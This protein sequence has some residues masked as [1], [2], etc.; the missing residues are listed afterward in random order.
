MRLAQSRALLLPVATRHMDAKTR[1]LVAHIADFEVIRT[2]TAD[3]GADP[4]KRADQELPAEVQR[5]AEGQQDVSLPQDHQRG[6][7]ADHLHPADRQRRRPLLRALHLGRS[8]YK[9]LNLLNR[10]F[11][12]RK[13]DKKI[14]GHDEVCL[15]YHMHQCTAPCISAVDRRDLHAGDRW[16][17]ALPQRPGRRNPASRSKRRWSRPSDAWNFERAAEL[18]DRINA[19]NHVLE[20]QKIVSPNGHERRRH[21]GRPGCGRRCRRAGG[22]PAQRQ[23]ARLRVLPDAGARRRR[24][25]RDP[26][27]LRHASS[28]PMRPWFR[29]D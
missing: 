27:R 6:V 11:P 17:G 14:T 21:R 22:V 2:D 18:R 3:R 5:H 4:R 23:D 12:Y 1:E 26:V 24:A 8:A 28:M 19:V 9:T 7:A 13:C 25:R 15:Y 20:R 29:R 10:L 16:R